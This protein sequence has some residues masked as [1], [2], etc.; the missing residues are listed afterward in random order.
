MIK[1]QYKQ[2]SVDMK[3]VKLTGIGSYAPETI[4]L[5]DDLSKIVETSDEWI[6]SRTGISKRHVVSGNETALSLAVAAAKEALAFANLDASEIDL[7]IVGTSMP[8]NLYPSQACELQG[9]IG[10][11]NAVAFD[12]VAACS[13]LIYSMSI[14]DQFLRYGAYKKAL[15]VGVDIH[16]R[17]LDWEDRGTCVLFG[18]GA[19]SFIMEADDD[20]SKNDVM[21]I[22]LNSD[23]SKSKELKIPLSGKNCPLVEPNDQ[24]P[25]YVY[26]NGKEIYK[27]AVT[28]VPKQIRNALEMANITI[29]DVDFFIPHQAN[30]RIINAIADKLSFPKEKI[31]SNLQEYGNTSTASIPLAINEAIKAGKVGTNKTLLLSGFGAGLTWGTAVIRWNAVDKR[32]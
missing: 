3:A 22:K 1:V 20:L 31:L 13:G 14:A 24:V 15:V 26:M 32:N 12:V 2:E 19:G 16:S 21:A 4:L 8:D 7:I 9:A 18:D 30:I 29:D 6:N 27:F 10:A 11:S 25:S 17:F 5:N 28:D 23:G